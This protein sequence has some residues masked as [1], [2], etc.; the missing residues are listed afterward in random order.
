MC[1]QPISRRCFVFCRPPHPPDTWAPS[2]NEA[3]VRQVPAASL[4]N[5][6]ERSDACRLGFSCS[7][8]ARSGPSHPPCPQLV[9][10]AR[11]EA[12]AKTKPASVGPLRSIS[13][14]K[15][16][17]AHARL[18]RFLREPRY[19]GGAAKGKIRNMR[20]RLLHMEKQHAGGA[21]RR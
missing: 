21:H 14:R 5:L 19:P 4:S 6:S 11:G 18:L 2:K 3:G 10:D 20:N 16:Q 9:E 7:L 13:T 1:K 8:S 17:L 12:A 15:L